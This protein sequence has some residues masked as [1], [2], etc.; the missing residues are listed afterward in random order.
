M[1]GFEMNGREY[2]QGVR[3]LPQAV[4]EGGRSGGIMPACSTGDRH[5]SPRKVSSGGH[6]DLSSITL[7]NRTR[8]FP[9]EVVPSSI[10]ET[11]SMEKFRPNVLWLKGRKSV[12]NFK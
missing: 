12:I 4:R 11:G 9:L 2:V 7:S 6:V 10:T 5:S 1:D 3:G 8:D